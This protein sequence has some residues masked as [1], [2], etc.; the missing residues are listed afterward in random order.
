MTENYPNPQTGGHTPDPHATAPL[1]GQPAG[2]PPAAPPAAGLATPPAPPRRG[3]KGFAAAVLAGALVVGGGAGL[4]GAAVWSAFDDEGTSTSAGSD[5]TSSQVVSASD[6]EAPKG[7]VEQ[8]AAKVLPSVV[9]IE[10]SGAQGA[11][12]GSGIVLSSDGVI[13]TNNHVI[14]AAADGGE[15][16]VAFSDGSRAEAEILGRDPLTDTAVIKAKG[17]DDLTP[18]TIGD[19]ESLDVGEQVVAIGS[20]FGLE[21]TVTSGIVSA[22][23]RPVNVGQDDQNNSTTYPAIQTD[24]AINPGNSGGPLVNMNG[25]VVG[26]NSSIR[27]ASSTGGEAGSIGLGFAIPVDPVLPIVDQMS[28]GERPTHARLGIS[29]SDPGARAAAEGPSGL[30]GQQQP[31]AE[32]EDDAPAVIGAE[33]VELGEDSTAGEAGIKAG[34]V[35]TAI[36]DTRINSADSLV[37][38]IR[39]YRPGDEVSVT[40][41]R[42]GQEQTVTLELASD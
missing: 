13:L 25:E 15:M 5:R 27:T 11:G 22:L 26:I 19:S 41:L 4:G 20:P 33:V 2:P 21:S 23:D 42:D 32:Q 34:D 17:V 37:A 3:R 1:H 12:S 18:A 29:V 38:T 8:V 10:V 16:T 31:Q 14:E 39:S 36:D 35:I 30:L 6:E 40:F 24:A 28:E 9:Q 7:S